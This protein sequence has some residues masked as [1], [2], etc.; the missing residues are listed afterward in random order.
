L[1]GKVKNCKKRRVFYYFL[2]YDYE[3]Y[4]GLL[5]NVPTIGEGADLKLVLFAIQDL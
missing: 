1:K 5:A 3:V 4:L 2:K